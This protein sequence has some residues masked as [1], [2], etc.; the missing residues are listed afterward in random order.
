VSRYFDALDPLREVPIDMALS[1]DEPVRK[2]ARN[3]DEDRNRGKA[4]PLPPPRQARLSKVLPKDVSIGP[5]ESTPDVPMVPEIVREIQATETSDRTPGLAIVIPKQLPPRVERHKPKDVAKEQVVS[6][7]N[8][9]T[10]MEGLTGRGAT[11]FGSGTGR[12]S[13]NGGLGKSFGIND[14]ELPIVHGGA[15]F[16][17]SKKG[18]LKGTLCFLPPGTQLLKNV[19]RCAPVGILYASVLNVSPRRFTH[20]FPG[21]SD[22]FEWFSIDFRGKF[23]VSAEGDYVFRLLSDDG[24][25]LWIDNTLVIDNDGQHS[26]LAKIKSW[27]LTHGK[28]SMRVLY[29]QGPRVHVALQLFVKPSGGVERLWS[30]EL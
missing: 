9:Q 7:M 13:G 10:V 29:Y 14:Q 1:T 28:H 26:P 20:G 19:T 25:L 2:Q 4:E 12:G 27:H 3:E 30:A 5:V 11:D 17:S 18:A 16:G 22:R 8:V 24:S 23:T 6:S 15:V 21:V